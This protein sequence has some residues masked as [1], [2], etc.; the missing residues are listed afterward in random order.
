MMEDE[1]YEHRCAGCFATLDVSDYDPNERPRYGCQI[2]GASLCSECDRRHGV[3]SG[4]ECQATYHEH[5][6]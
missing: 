2:C 3:C 4:Y 5:M 6:Y 1:T